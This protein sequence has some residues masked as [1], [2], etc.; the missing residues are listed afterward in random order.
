M[1]EFLGHDDEVHAPAFDLTYLRRLL[2]FVRPYARGFAVCLAILCVSFALELSGPYLLRLTIDGP[3]TDGLEGRA[4]DRDEVLLLGAAFLAVSILSVLSLYTYTA[5]TA[6]NG[7]RVIRDLRVHLYRHILHLGPRFFD[8][9]PTGRLVTR[10]TSDVENLNELITT[11]VLQTVFDLLKIFGI[12]A[13]LFVLDPQLALYT[14]AVTPV[15]VVI[16]LVFRKYARIAFRDVRGRLARQNGF[17]SEVV[18]GIRATRAYD[19]HQAVQQHF[20]QLN[21][22]T[23]LGAGFEVRDVHPT[24]YGRI[25]PIE[26]P[27]GPNIGLIASLSTYARVNEF[28]FV[29]TPYRTVSNGQVSDS[30]EFYNAIVEDDYIIAQANAQL[31]KRKRFVNEIV[32]ARQGGDFILSPSDK[33]DLMDV[34]PKQLISIAASLIPF[35][36]NDDANRALMGSNMQRQ[37]VPLLVSEAPLVGTGME[38]IVARDSGAV[39][40]SENDGEVISS[41]ASR[42][43]VRSSGKHLKNRLVNSTVDIYN[44]AKYQRS[45]QNTCINQRPLVK[46][47]QKLKAGDVIADGPSTDRGEL[48]L[49]RNVLV[50]FMP[51]DGYNFE[52]AIVISEKVVKEDVFTSVHI[53]EFEVEA[54]DTK[55]GKEEITRDISNVGE[56][57][58]KNLDDSGII[59]IGA[60]VKPND[61]LVG[62]ITPKGETQLSPEEKLLKAIFG[63]KAGDVRDTSMRVP[64]GIQGTVI[65]VKMFSRKG[66]DKDSRTLAIEEEEIARIEKD[67]GDE[68]QIVKSETEKKLHSFLLGKDTTLVRM[69]ATAPISPQLPL[70]ASRIPEVLRVGSGRDRRSEAILEGRIS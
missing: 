27:E 2:P 56:D 65:D 24:H 34:S 1:V 41:D 64:P 57:A 16:S 32:D 9:S 53:E 33:V 35:L 31:D 23:K 51:W 22:Q 49:G 40:V 58:L 6:L 5:L 59:R 11:G 18:G 13:V 37:A 50:A 47:G 44:L 48:A 4:V 25:C 14:L 46:T 70:R 36:E 20:E 45:N 17:T 12:L 62:K 52:D 15:I 42:V 28:G 61:I 30:V 29:E 38:A 19:Q 26:T 3:V 67:F 55:Q 66:V 69:A 68:I 21:H 60:S 8:R 54:R 63:E 39:L 10:V 43:V 7:Q